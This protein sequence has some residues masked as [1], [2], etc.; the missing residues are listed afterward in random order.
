MDANELSELVKKHDKNASQI[1]ADL[2][3]SRSGFSNWINGKRK[4]DPRDSKLLRL[5]FY[6]DIPF[7]GERP[8]SEPDLSSSLN[9]SEEDWDE[10][11][12][13]ATRAGKTAG[14]WIAENIREYL[15]I[16][17]RQVRPDSQHDNI[18]E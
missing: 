10:I 17:E 16:R 2:G 13:I 8:H 5:Y 18:D 7:K 11:S 9:F 1:A 6:G 3:I 14:E 4:I 12:S 15:A